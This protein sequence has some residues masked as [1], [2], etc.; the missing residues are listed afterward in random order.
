[1]HVAVVRCHGHPQR[2]PAHPVQ[3]LGRGGAGG[4]VANLDRYQ[5]GGER[6]DVDVVTQRQAADEPDPDPAA[7]RDPQFPV[8]ASAS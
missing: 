7:V 5:A 4:V 3:H 8:L 2:A 1:M 6:A